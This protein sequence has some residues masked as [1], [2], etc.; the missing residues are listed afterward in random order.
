L[1]NKEKQNL[2]RFINSKEL[3][4]FSY[5]IF[6]LDQTLYDY[7]EC[8]KIAIEKITKFMKKEFGLD[9][10]MIL[11]SYMN[12]RKTTNNGL[13]NT[14]SMHSRFLYI[15]KM[16]ENLSIDNKINYTVE[17]YNLYWE[18]F[19]KKMQLFDWVEPTFKK[20]YNKNITIMIATDFSAK[21]QFEKI[22]ILKIEKYIETIITSQEIGEEKPSTKFSERVMKLTNANSN[23][24]FYVGDNPKKDN[25]LSKYGVKTFII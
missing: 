10:K 16:L 19:F 15:K 24:I 21:I 23:A 9:E 12:S 25:F 5:A 20:L 18:E 1:K 13:K 11:E 3:D 8:N 6:D 4:N 2:I 22:K 17:I 7:E 14:S